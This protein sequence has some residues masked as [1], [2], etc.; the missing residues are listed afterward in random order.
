MHP[1]FKNNAEHCDCCS[2]CTSVLEGGLLPDVTDLLLPPTQPYESSP[3][4]LHQAKSG[5]LLLLL[6]SEVN[7]V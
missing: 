2:I 4:T 6:L 1:A 3:E 7:L 5:L